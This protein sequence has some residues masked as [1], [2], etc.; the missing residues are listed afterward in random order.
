MLNERLERERGVRLAVRIGIHTGP[1]VAG[2]MGAGGRAEHL[3]VG[4]TPNIAAR[5]QAMA[6]PDTVVLGDTTYRLVH[7]F[8]ECESLGELALRGL[9][10]ATEAYRALHDTGMKSRFEIAASKGLLPLVG[11]E[12]E[13]ETLRASFA[14]ARDGRGQAVSIVG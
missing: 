1:V 14:R 7:G 12:H 11:R 3:A 9:S 5:L 8:F 10:Q 13:Q 4:Q 2:A 6:A